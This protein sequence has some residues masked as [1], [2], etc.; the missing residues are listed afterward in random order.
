MGLL[1]CS[2]V[3]SLL[4]QNGLIKGSVKD[5]AGAPVNFANVI[6]L[7]EKDSSL[8]R[9]MVTGTDGTF[10]LVLEPSD[11]P[12]F[13]RVSAMGFEDRY[14]ARPLGDIGTIILTAATFQLDEVSVMGL[15][16]LTRLTDDGIR[17]VVSG[18]YLAKT[19]T[20]FELLGKMPFVSCSG[21][22]IEVLGKGAPAV[23]INGRQVRDQSELTRL[24][25][26]EIKAVE[27]VTTP[28]ARYASTVNAVIRITTKA[29]FG[30][31]FSLSDQTT[32]GLKHYGYLFEQV[33]LNYRRRG[34]DLFGMLN[35]ERYRERPRVDN[36]TSYYL[37]S[38]VIEQST[39][40][41]ETVRYPVYE[42]KLGLNYKTGH[43]DLGFYYDFSL[44]PSES[45]G[46]SVAS[47]YVNGAFRELL[48]NRDAVSRH[49]RQHLLSAY[50][51]GVFGK[52]RLSANFD[53]MWQRNNRRA[54]EKDLSSVHPPRS[55]S[56]VNDVANRLLAGN[57]IMSFPVWQGDMRLGAEVSSIWRNDRYSGDAD[58]ILGNDNHIDETTTALFMEVGQK[59]GSVAVSGGLR[60]EYTDSRFYK[61]AELQPDQSRRYHNVAPSVSVSFP[62]GAVQAKFSY[63]RKTSRPAFE[64][65]SSAVKYIDRYT[66]ESGNPNLRPIYRDYLSLSSSWKDL[67]VELS[68]SSTKDY[69]MWQT[70]PYPGSSEATLLTRENMPRFSSYGIMLNYSPTFL[71]FWHPVWLFAIT[72]QD[73][74][75]THWGET[76]RLKSPIGVFRFNNAFRLPW[77]MWLNADLSAR[78]SG[79]GDNARLKSCWA[80]NV[81][82]YK[83]FADDA[84]SIKL[85]LNDLFATWRQEFTI[86]DAL[87]RTSV[88]KISDTRDLTLTVRYNFNLAR[89]RYGGRGVGNVEKSRF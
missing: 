30:E 81:A 20:A 16:P 28:G 37:T 47:R 69:F 55:F 29:S 57:A 17:V 44:R 63:T 11:P 6:L 31:G 15:Q 76:L 68:Y 43:H 77:D 85:Q 83:S 10:R 46:S 82:L 70:V 88:N 39:T 41:G 19:G 86:Y 62:V 64:Q 56:T 60:W 50:Y 4:A 25:S 18:T 22:R 74:K 1:L 84:W 75:L 72:A 2:P 7:A 54:G 23:Y 3:C 59:W 5:E 67:V 14:I 32:L 24:S 26:S 79:N 78:T 48:N 12:A 87:S 61:F 51:S 40:G 21:S 53:A 71:G 27:V 42:G 9:G 13:L 34:L 33:N 52:W 65:L 8:I 45:T 38:G 73:F 49:N 58:Y 66:Y 89:S 35:Y 80:C 36:A